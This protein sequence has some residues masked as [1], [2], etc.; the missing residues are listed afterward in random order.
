LEAVE[1]EVSI[2]E[3][4]KV[5][6]VALAEVVDKEI[7][8]APVVVAQEHLVK[9]IMVDPEVAMMGIQFRA[10]A[11]A[12]VLVVVAAVADI[13]SPVVLVGLV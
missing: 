7:V 13:I 1:V 11:V 6:L 8:E 2:T 10:V 12:E 4:S 5:A 3:T 9:V